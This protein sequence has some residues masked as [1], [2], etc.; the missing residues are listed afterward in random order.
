MRSLWTPNWT[1]ARGNDRQTGGAFEV[2]ECGGP[3]LVACCATCYNEF[4][5]S[6]TDIYVLAGVL[7][8]NGQPATLRELAQELHIDH[9]V[10]HRALARA[11]EAGLYRKKSKEV[12]RPNLEELLTHAARF[13]APAQLGP[14]TRGVQTAWAAEPISNVIRQPSDELPPVWP[15]ADG[16]V[17]GQELKPLHPSAARAVEDN[18]KLAELLTIIDSLRAGDLRTRKVTADELRSVLHATA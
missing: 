13:I 6:P 5:V 14:L 16:S 8:E 1:P 3:G 17:R 4:V 15:Y 7:A 9:T 2:S 11:E 10:V 12:N 18:A